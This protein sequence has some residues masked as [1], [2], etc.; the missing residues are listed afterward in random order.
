MNLAGRDL[1]QLV[2][3]RALLEEVNVTR[4]GDRIE[5]GQSSMSSALSRLRSQFD[6]ELLVRVGR[7]YELTPLAREL[8]PQ[9][10]RTLPLIEKVLGA[11]IPF[12]PATST[13]LYS[14]MMSD[15]ATLEVKGALDAALEVAPMVHFDVVPVPSHAPDAQR[16][17]LKHDFVVAPPGAGLE[18]ESFTLFTDHYVCLLDRDNPALAA[19]VLSM[20]AFS[21]LPL[22]VRAPGYLHLTPADQRLRELGVAGNAHVKTSSYLPLPS[23]VA[24]TDLIA[25]VP[26]RLAD[27]LG[28][29]TGTMTA[30]TPFDRV[31]M[32]EALW[33]HPS[34]NSDPSHV[35]L[36]DLIKQSFV[37]DEADPI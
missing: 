8:L 12:D 28:P 31:E 21:S 10:Q 11:D 7:D 34:K 26:S 35:W 24:G 19:G 1:N 20:D 18:G 16:D 6:D 33:W 3:L 4:A 36:R 13:R 23:I 9:L 22:A 2:A 5:M 15:Y 17:L 32:T 37:G 25:V 27:R 30:P 14:L 29:V